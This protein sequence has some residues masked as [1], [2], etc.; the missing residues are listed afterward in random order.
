MVS[1][2]SRWHKTKPQVALAAAAVA[3]VLTF[4][5][6]RVLA[7]RQSYIHDLFLERS[8]I[9]YASVF[10]FWVTIAILTIKHSS[11]Y[12]EQEAFEAAQK[13][14]S[15]PEFGSSLIWSDAQMVSGKFAG[16]E[17][18]QHHASIAFSRI[19]NALDRL[20]KTQSTAALENY[21]H[22]RSDYDAGRLENSYAGIRYFV[23]LLPTLGLIGTVLGLGLGMSRF[24]RVIQGAS[25]FETIKSALP[26]VTENLG[27]A[28]DATFLAILL[29]AIA[30]FYMAFLQQR[31]EHILEEID[32]L[33]VDEVCA[34][35]QEHSSA[36]T[37]IIQALS[38]QIQLIVRA[39]NGNRAQIEKDLERLPALFAGRLQTFGATISEHLNAIATSTTQ[40]ATQQETAADLFS[41]IKEIKAAQERLSEN[42][43]AFRS[44]VT[45]S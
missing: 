19:L 33:C 23:W 21:F 35:F 12:Y 44:S 43:I 38:E 40:L 6:V 8:W 36:S 14:V 11:S 18:Q 4:L 31:Q 20:R 37:E 5:L 39:S 32:H 7:P 13:I 26:D 2:I 15:G 30:A 3:T 10:C 29:S 24:G 34:L 9:Q 42:I 1:K 25:G 28:F 17:Y 45:E 16:Q 27:T 22:T 41:E